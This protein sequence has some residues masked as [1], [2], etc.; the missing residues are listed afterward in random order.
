M[1]PFPCIYFIFNVELQYI[2]K[3][4]TFIEYI[5]LHGT[6]TV[7]IGELVGKRLNACNAYITHQA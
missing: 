7:A 6:C 1:S 4:N 5:S 3:I 2:L